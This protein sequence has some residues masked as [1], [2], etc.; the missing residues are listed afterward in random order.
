MTVERDALG[1]DAPAPPDHPARQGLPAGHPTGP[2]VGDAVPDFTL[3]DSSGR[4]VR[5]H[6]HRAGR[7]AAI[8]F[9]RSAVW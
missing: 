8:V 3:P 6:E 7:P 4:M 9:F 2:S 5:L 1:F